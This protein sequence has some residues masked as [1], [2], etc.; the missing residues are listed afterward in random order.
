M[1]WKWKPDAVNLDPNMM[2]LCDFNYGV[3]DEWVADWRI[4]YFHRAAVETPQ[5]LLFYGRGIISCCV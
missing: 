5:Q 3:T 1:K 2:N 4:E